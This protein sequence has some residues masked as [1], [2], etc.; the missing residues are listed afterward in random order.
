MSTRADAPT[1]G[2]AGSTNLPLVLGGPLEDP[3]PRPASLLHGRVRV[4]QRGG[5]AGP[6][7]ADH[8]QVVGHAAEPP[9][10]TNPPSTDGSSSGCST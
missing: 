6:S 10:Y 3:D 7:A 2:T 8:E 5:E 9:G 1:I 4:G